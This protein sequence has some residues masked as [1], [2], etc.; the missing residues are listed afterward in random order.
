LGNS[1]Y[2]TPIKRCGFEIG[3][4]EISVTT[5]G[6][7]TPETGSHTGQWVFT[8]SDTALCFVKR[9]GLAD[10]KGRVIYLGE[11]SYRGDFIRL[12]MK[13]K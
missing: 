13:L 3:H 7:I 1:K 6:V 4:V 8:G 2:R 12:Q 11:V 10:A 9:F 5:G